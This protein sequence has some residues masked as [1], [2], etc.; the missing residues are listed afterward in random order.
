MD[1]CQQPHQ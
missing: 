1:Y